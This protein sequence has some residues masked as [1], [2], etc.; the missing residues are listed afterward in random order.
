MKAQKNTQTP[1]EILEAIRNL[2]EEE[3]ATLSILADKALSDELLKRR[4]EVVEE[5]QQGELIGE[6]DLFRDM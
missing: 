4:Q 3:K 1:L 5:M 6:K 2:T